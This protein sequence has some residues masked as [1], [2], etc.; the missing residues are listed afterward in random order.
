MV[1]AAII[2]KGDKMRKVLFTAVLVLLGGMVLATADAA[3][4]KEAFEAK[5]ANCHGKDGKG[6]TTMGK[7]LK[8]ADLTDAKAMSGKTEADI[9]KIITQGGKA[10]GRSAMMG[11]WGEKLGEQ[12]VKDVVEHIKDLCKCKLK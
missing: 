4:G 9:A 12:G 11:A 5:C 10:V 7:K 6:D 3:K 8:L 2:I 1:L